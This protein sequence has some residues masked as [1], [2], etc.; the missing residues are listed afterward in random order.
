MRTVSGYLCAIP[1]VAALSISFAVAAPDVELLVAA[2]NGDPKLVAQLLAQGASVNAREQKP[3]NVGRTPLHYAASG[4]KAAGQGLHLDVARLLVEKG[5]DVNAQAVGGYTPL[6]VASGLGN[7]PMVTYLLS[8]RADPNAMDKRGT[9]LTAAVVQGHLSVVRLLLKAGANMDIAGDLGRPID[10]I[11]PIAS[12]TPDHDAIFIALID[13]GANVKPR[14]KGGNPLTFAISRGR[15]KVA[16]ALIGKGAVVNA[17]AVE[18]AGTRADR[19][20]VDALIRQNPK[21]FTGD[22]VGS[23][24]LHGAVCSKDPAFFDWV[25]K[26]TP[27]VNARGY[28]GKAPL[29]MAARCGN[30]QAI[31]ALIAKHADV[32]RKDDK[33]NAPISELHGTK[34]TPCLKLLLDARADPNVESARGSTPL[35]SAVY[36]NDPEFARLLIVR[37]ADVNRKNRFGQT[38]LHE[39]ARL[40]K[41]ETAGALL[42]S[43]DLR[44][45]E[46]NDKGETALHMA[47]K[48]GAPEMVAMLLKRGANRTLR[49]PEGKTALELADRGGPYKATADLLR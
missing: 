38:A 33:G 25:L 5:A 40:Y 43:K 16:L 8:K 4:Y 37:G 27:D 15:T 12:W 2:R 31:N 7:A 24:L 45:D 48:S 41:V 19:E 18:A 3:P 11:S 36:M 44:V 20:V 46:R 21:V 39:S 47:A 14:E 42:E 10:M 32:N 49:T 23:T 9:P 6:H 29:H 30:A 1:F 28:E 13:A 17:F 26:Q 22:G 35:M 34:L